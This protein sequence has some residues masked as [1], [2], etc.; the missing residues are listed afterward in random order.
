MMKY[1]PFCGDKKKIFL[2]NRDIDVNR[3]HNIK[4]QLDKLG[5][6]FYKFKNNIEEDERLIKKY[7]INEGLFKSPKSAIY[8]FISH[9]QI[10]KYV[11][12]NNLDS[13]LILEDDAEFDPDFET[14][15]N[16]YWKHVPNNWD[17]VMLGCTTMCDNKPNLINNITALIM[18]IK[19]TNSPINEYVNK[20]QS[21]TG[22]HGY[23]INN[24]LCKALIEYCEQ[25]IYDGPEKQMCQ[26]LQL[27]KNSKWNVYAF[28]DYL[29]TQNLLIRHSN[30]TPLS[31]PVF[32]NTILD[33]INISDNNKYKISLGYALNDKM[34]GFCGTKIRTI[35]VVF[36]FIGLIGGQCNNH[37][38]I[39]LLITLIIIDAIYNY[40]NEV[41]FYKWEDYI[42][43]LMNILIGFNISR[44]YPL[45]KCINIR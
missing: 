21:F 32:V 34:Y 15:F 2:I 29:I 3:Y 35:M 40:Y 38:G 18:N 20:I 11:V 28:D 45:K 4:K 19:Y 10:W 16:K 30:N 7:T 42:I 14:K 24:K 43:V 31:A 27:Q 5:L 23:I 44:L 36:F 1:P 26:F 9:I 41:S 17:M 12:D 6:S 25:E 39:H 33:H 37:N 8:V 22:M 13:V